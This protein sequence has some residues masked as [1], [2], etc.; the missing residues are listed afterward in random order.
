M[1][2][3]MTELRN[4]LNDGENLKTLVNEGLQSGTLEDTAHLERLSELSSRLLARNRARAA[5]TKFCHQVDHK[6]DGS[7]EVATA[8][9]V[10]SYFRRTQGSETSEGTVWSSKSFLNAL[11]SAPDGT[12]LCVRFSL[13]ALPSQTVED[14]LLY[15]M[16]LAVVQAAPMVAAGGKKYNLAFEVADLSAA[17]ASEWT[18]DPVQ[19]SKLEEL[20]A[21][22]G[23]STLR[24]TPVG[25]LGMILAV[26]GGAQLDEEPFFSEM[27]RAVKEAHREELL[28]R[29][30]NVF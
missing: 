21:M 2:K 22:L 17:R 9:L 20:C 25:V 1:S 15:D 10:P 19:R 26:A 29:A 3:E 28:A 30:G 12:V 16:T 5:V 7:A 18:L 14:E 11:P 4:I 24:W 8:C 23:L 13:S 6:H 27:L